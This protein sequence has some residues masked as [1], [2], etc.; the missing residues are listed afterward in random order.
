M[1]KKEDICDQ[2]G[3][4]GATKEATPEVTTSSNEVIDRTEEVQREFSNFLFGPV[5]NNAAFIN[6]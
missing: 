1:S 4:I 2:E 6:G 3:R 5:V